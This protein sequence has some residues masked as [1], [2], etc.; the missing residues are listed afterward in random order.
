VFIVEEE[1]RGKNNNKKVGKVSG[2]GR[3]NRTWGEGR[4]KEGER[5]KQRE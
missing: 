5:L 2:K 1:E 4:G 3:G